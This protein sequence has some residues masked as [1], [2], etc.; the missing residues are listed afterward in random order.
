LPERL[1]PKKEATGAGL[2]NCGSSAKSHGF[3]VFGFS[4]IFSPQVR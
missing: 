2:S 4:F 1:E 3:V